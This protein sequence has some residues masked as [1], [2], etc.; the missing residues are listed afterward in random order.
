MRRWWLLLFAAVWLPAHLVLGKDPAPETKKESAAGTALLLHIN[1]A[2]GP[3]LSHYISQGLKR[4][5]EDGN[6]LVILRMDTPGGLDTAM[7]D[8]IK[9]ILASPVPVVTFV[10]P[11]GARA[12]SAGTYILYASHVAAMAPATNLGSATPVPVGGEPPVQPTPTPVDDKQADDD[13]AADKAA[14]DEKGTPLPGGAMERKVVNDAVAYLRSLAQLRGRN[15]EWAEK[16]VREGANLPADE[17]LAQKVIDLIATD[18]PDLLKKL[19]GRK[20][21]IGAGEVTLATEHMTV[22]TVEPDWRTELLSVITNPTVAYGLLLIGIYGLLFEGYNPGAVLPGVVGAICLLLALF[23]FQVLPVNYAGLALIVLG[24]LLVVAEAFMPSFGALG[25]GGVIAF[26]IGSIMLFDTSVPGFQV[27]MPVIAAIA[28]V[29]GVILF[30]IVWMF[31]RARRRPVV[32]GVDQLLGSTAEAID[33][34]SEQGMVRLGGELWKARSSAP[35]RPGQR[36]RVVR[37]EGLEVWVEPL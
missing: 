9:D 18:V 15:A 1:G 24:A 21:T 35:L 6:S 27:A 11:S 23:A 33:G 22:E 4:A 2:I 32:T 25:V 13:K 30:G 3:A 14:R 29:A 16:A 5:A 31:G 10:S 36:A 8:I 37:V 34:F 17:A 19:E 7:R 26:V 20:I 12:A 28:F